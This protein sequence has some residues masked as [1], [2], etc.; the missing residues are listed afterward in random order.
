MNEKEYT[1]QFV[2][3]PIEITEEKVENKTRLIVGKINN[4][5]TNYHWI[6]DDNEEFEIGDYAI[7]ENMNDYDL[8]KIIGVIDTNNKYQKY[9]TNC[10]I[11]KKVVMIIDRYDIRN[12]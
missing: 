7:V 1:F 10:N 3:K 12:D 5:N 2:G 4:C 9:I 8:V 11:N 6:V